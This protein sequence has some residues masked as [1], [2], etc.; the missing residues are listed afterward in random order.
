MKVLLAASPDRPATASILGEVRRIVAKHAEIVA[1]IQAD[2]AALSANL[3][4]DRMVAVGGDGTLIAQL[5]RILD[6]GMPLVGVNSGRLGFLAEFDPISLE[7]QADSIFGPNPLVRQRMVMDVI[8]KRKDGTVVYHGVAVNDVVVSAGFPFRMIELRL[9]FSGNVGPDVSGDGIIIASPV[10]STAY[11][12]S[13][14]GPI[15]HPDIEALIVTPICPHSL[16]FRPIVV[17]SHLDIS[18]RVERANDGTTLMLDGQTNIRLAVGDMIQVGRH[19]SMA[20]LIGNPEVTY[21]QQLLSKMRWAA[22]P[23]YRDRGA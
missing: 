21:W 20:R 18:V 23:T 22:P 11:T 7:E 17:P 10:G 19:Q 4:F 9:E 6:R 13:A 8:V 1:E 5:R 15:V 3:L 16:G 14:G 2:S 12:V